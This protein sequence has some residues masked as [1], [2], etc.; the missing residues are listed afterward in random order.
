MSSPFDVELQIGTVERAEKFTEARKEE[1]VKLWIKIGD[2]KYQSAAQLGHNYKI[3]DLE[4]RQVLCATN[5][6]DMNIGGFKS[7][8]LTAGVP[9]KSGEVILV[10]PDKEAP[11]GATL[12]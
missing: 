6:E 4:G 8:V 12:F 3:E 1:M 11:S 9:N 10:S 2:S 5:L 7:E